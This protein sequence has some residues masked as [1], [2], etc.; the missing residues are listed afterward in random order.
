MVL[1]VSI[2]LFN[3]RVFRLLNASVQRKFSLH[4]R[5]SP[6]KNW[7]DCRAHFLDSKRILIVG[8]RYR[9]PSISAASIRKYAVL[10][11][12][13]LPSSHSYPPS[14]LSYAPSVSVCIT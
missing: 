4:F 5:L 10:S 2:L 1:S 8:W 13:Y 12:N 6:K 9:L 7:R 3:L 14:S 11:R